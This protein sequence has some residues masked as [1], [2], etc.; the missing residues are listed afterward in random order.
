MPMTTR[1]ASAQ[2]NVNEE[3]EGRDVPDSQHLRV[4]IDSAGRQ[5]GS[6]S[7]VPTHSCI[8]IATQ[9][10]GD[11]R[12]D[13]GFNFTK[14][15]KNVIMQRLA[16]LVIGI[17]VIITIILLE[18][19]LKVDIIDEKQLVKDLAGQLLVN[20]QSSVPTSPTPSTAE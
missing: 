19:T 8:N 20:A 12:D 15:A 11:E 14:C 3:V 1:A 5:F 17:L 10:D 6:T 9:I 7:A 2:E 13:H 18:R 4:V 16:Y